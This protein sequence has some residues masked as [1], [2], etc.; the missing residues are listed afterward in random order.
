MMYKEG[1]MWQS[2]EFIPVREPIPSTR[3]RTSI[4]SIFP[5]HAQTEATR[6]IFWA[7]PG[8]AKA[9]YLK[10]KR[11]FDLFV[12]LLL[13]P[14]VFILTAIIS[15]FIWLEDGGAP[16]FMQM[17]TGQYGRRF[18]MFKFR[19]MVRNAEELKQRLM[20]LNELKPPD[21]KIS[22]DPRITRVGKFLR[23]TSLDELPQIFNVIKGDMSL[24]GPRP[25]SFK[26]ETYELWQMRRL[27]ATPGLTGLW[28]ISGRSDLEFDERVQL[29]LAYIEK[30]SLWFDL[31]ILW[32]TIGSVFRGHGAY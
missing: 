17:R 11:A 26:A 16:F 3:N 21:F 10:R 14:V 22:N 9:A 8:A 19:T 25:T 32:R 29:D 12:C 6:P 7:R 2:E 31:V 1:L 23:R 4:T 28:Q 27:E 15:Y 13:L 20:H 24:V 18:V 30:Q 5:T